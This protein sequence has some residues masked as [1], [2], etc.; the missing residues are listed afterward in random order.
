[1]I[2]PTIGSVVLVFSSSRAEPMPAFICKVFDDRTINVGGFNETGA[3]FAS[4][5]QL[6]H[7]DSSDGPVSSIYAKMMEEKPE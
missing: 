4:R 2:K 3:P 7:G 5:L 6:V 1:M